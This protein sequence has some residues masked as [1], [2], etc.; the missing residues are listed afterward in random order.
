MRQGDYDNDALSASQPGVVGSMFVN[1]SDLMQERRGRRKCVPVVQLFQL[2]PKP[3]LHLPPLIR[4]LHPWIRNP[5]QRCP[6]HH[7]RE[8]RPQRGV[9]D[10]K[11][12][13]DQST[14]NGRLTLRFKLGII[15]DFLE[16]LLGL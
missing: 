12:C 8:C 10:P 9:S 11:P 7:L 2:S 3:G 4:Y 15:W 6:Q 5:Q 14:L 13:D 16:S 1:V